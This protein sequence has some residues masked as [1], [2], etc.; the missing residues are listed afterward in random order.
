MV[1]GSGNGTVTDLDGNYSI[2]VTGE[3]SVLTFSFIGFKSQSITVG[4][5]PVLNVQL[6]ED[7]ELEEVIVVGY[8]V[9][10]KANLTG[11]VAAIG[12]EKLAKK[13]VPDIRQALQGEA[14]GLTIIDHGGVPG[15][16]DLRVNIRGVGSLSA[17]TYPL[18]LV[19]GI[20]MPNE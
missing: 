16:E 3:E 12:G 18:V 5:R 6:V 20:E 13:T 11:S 10:K 8:G 19:D 15:S 17:G 4:N 2:S 1:K 9:Q 14:T 7:T